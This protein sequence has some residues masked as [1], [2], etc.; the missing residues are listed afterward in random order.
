MKTDKPINSRFNSYSGYILKVTRVHF[1]D[2]ILKSK[3]LTAIKIWQ[4]HTCIRFEPY[5]LDTHSAHRSKV[6]IRNRGQ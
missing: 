3:V 2:E 1:L 4:Q 6:L 5:S